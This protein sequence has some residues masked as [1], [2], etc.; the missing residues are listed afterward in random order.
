MPEHSAQPDF[1]EVYGPEAQLTPRMA[2]YLWSAALF[3]AD[4]YRDGD[5]L[6][7]LKRELPP[8]A[9]RLTDNAWMRRFVS[10]FR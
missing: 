2:A 6:E 10:C 9:R 7:L 4:T 1:A 3:I 5:Q 8:V